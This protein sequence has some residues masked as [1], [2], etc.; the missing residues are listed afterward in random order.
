MC[1]LRKIQRS[2]YPWGACI[3]AFLR[4]FLLAR[5]SWRGELAAA[6]PPAASDWTPVAP[7]ESVVW[8]KQ[9][10]LLDHS[11]PGLPP[12]LRFDFSELRFKCTE[13]GN[14]RHAQGG[15]T[16][17]SLRFCL[18][19]L[20]CLLA[21]NFILN[22]NIPRRKCTFPRYTIKWIFP[23]WTVVWPAPRQVKRLLP[24]PLTICV[25]PLLSAPQHPPHHP[26]HSSHH[27]SHFS[28][29]RSHELVGNSGKQ[30]LR[31]RWAF[32]RITLGSSTEERERQGA[33]LS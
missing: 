30:T 20:I 18:I 10:R 19:L 8:L 31:E 25:L 29:C 4:V 24:A 13:K 16:K 1:L 9:H 15:G 3:L 12:S 23:V 21:F 14:L 6:S 27:R 33:E 32:R 7:P 28:Q 2:R 5:Q 26:P 22:Y 11:W 17:Y